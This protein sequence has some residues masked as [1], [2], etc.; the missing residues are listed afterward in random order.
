[1]SDVVIGYNE[2][3]KNDGLVM[4]FMCV[5]VCF[6]IRLYLINVISQKRNLNSSY[7]LHVDSQFKEKVFC[8]FW[9]WPKVI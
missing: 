6:L 7:T 3:C 2:L 5:C 8:C 9:W 4:A 1:M